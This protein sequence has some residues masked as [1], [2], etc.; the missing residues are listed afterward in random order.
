MSPSNAL[1]VQHGSIQIRSEMTS[2]QVALVKRTIAKDASDDE[3]QLFTAV[4]NR[5]GLDPFSR[6]IFAIRRSGV[7]KAE[8]SIDGLRVVAERT[9]KWNRG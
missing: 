5:T 3:L 9:D 2:E 6:Q 4:C 8:V 1:A 7:L